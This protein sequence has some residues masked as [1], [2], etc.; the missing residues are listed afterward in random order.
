M[1]S[2]ASEN[3][4][5]L[6]Y[7]SGDYQESLTNKSG[8]KLSSH[9]NYLIVFRQSMGKWLIQEHVWTGETPAAN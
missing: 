8:A 7:D 6:A 3:S 5:A 4:G 1:H 9:G 2:V